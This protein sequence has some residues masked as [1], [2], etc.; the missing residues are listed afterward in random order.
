[1]PERSNGKGLKKSSPWS[2]RLGVGSG[3][4]G[5]DLETLL[6]KKTIEGG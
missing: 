1:M 5:P 3:T 4:N 6:L 2:S